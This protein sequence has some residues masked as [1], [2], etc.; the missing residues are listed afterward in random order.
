MISWRQK[1]Q[2][3]AV[4]LTQFF[5]LLCQT[6]RILKN[7]SHW[8]EAFSSSR[9]RGESDL[10]PSVDQSMAVQLALKHKYI[11]IGGPAGTGKTHVLHQ[12]YK[13]FTEKGKIVLV[14]ASTGRA[15]ENIGGSTF[16][17]IF[18]FRG[19]QKNRFIRLSDVI[20]L[21]EIS[22]ITPKLL[23]TLEANAR[24]MRQANQLFGGIRMVLC[25]DF[26]QLPPVDKDS[27]GN[28]LFENKL[29]REQFHHFALST[30]Q[31]V[32]REYT[33][34]RDALGLLRRGMFSPIW[35]VLQ[36]NQPKQ[37]L[38]HHS[39]TTFLFPKCAEANR[40]NM[41]ELESL[42]GPSVHFFPRLTS[43][44]LGAEWTHSLVFSMPKC[45]DT[46]K[47]YPFEKIHSLLWRSCIPVR[48]RNTLQE[49]YLVV[50]YLDS[51][52]GTYFCH[53]NIEYVC[54][55]IYTGGKSDRKMGRKLLRAINTLG[56]FVHSGKVDIVHR[57]AEARIQKP[58]IDM[59]NLELRAGARVMLTKNFTRSLV[60]GSLGFVETFVP[61]LDFD[62]R[63]LSEHHY[64]Y[65]DA[66]ID[67]CQ[68][69]REILPMLPVVRFD[70][71]ETV[72]IPPIQES[73][74][75][76]PIVH[77]ISMALY[78]F[79][80]FSDTPSLFTRCRALRLLGLL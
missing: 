40:Q 11:F 38:A 5:R 52:D 15:A 63:I 74:G 18:G 21:D 49:K 1:Y 24:N 30:I 22:M 10:E 65:I 34:F 31:R 72:T 64:K 36:Q 23:E 54:Q 35:Q 76:L 80:L 56:G 51:N 42:S 50:K 75:A 69:S 26:L 66:Y 14:T 41:I 45:E 27:Q 62:T 13:H 8:P 16:Q 2:Q 77:I 17:S 58:R 7:S 3:R 68:K 73:F 78:E 71:G 28:P 12:I 43:L 60:N 67:A 25:G 57:Y 46:G 6:P 53:V 39:K 47:V 9:W 4:H 48:L 59:Q 70:S 29:F 55:K 33:H 20:I 19:D 44:Q 37:P 61:A 79:H 32:F